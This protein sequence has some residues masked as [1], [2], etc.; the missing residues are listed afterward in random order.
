MNNTLHETRVALAA[1]WSQELRVRVT[2]FVLYQSLR[3]R[4]MAMGI[5]TYPCTLIM[6]WAPCKTGIPAAVL[7]ALLSIG[8]P[9][10]RSTRTAIAALIPPFIS[11]LQ[12]CPTPPA[13]PWSPA[14]PHAPSTSRGRSRGSRAR[15]RQSQDTPSSRGKE[16]SG[17]DAHCHKGGTLFHRVTPHFWASIVNLDCF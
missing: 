9:I 4:L 16:G 6:A 5:L 7:C 15:K 12:T 11:P 17:P 13:A 14:S 10:A 2:Q 3:V 1:R 8:K